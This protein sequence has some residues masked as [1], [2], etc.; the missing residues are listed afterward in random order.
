M[1][2][3]ELGVYENEPEQR[4]NVARE[5][6]NLEDPDMIEDAHTK[7]LRNRWKQMEVEAHGDK[8]IAPQ[9]KPRPRVKKLWE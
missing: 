7:S 6:D 4:D 2:S 3:K 5:S 9:V 1:G 8:N